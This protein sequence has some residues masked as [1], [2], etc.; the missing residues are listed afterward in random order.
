MRLLDYRGY[1]AVIVLYV[2]GC[3]ADLRGNYSFIRSTIKGILQ[4]KK[5]V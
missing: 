2:V 3:T 5:W 4:F 1:A